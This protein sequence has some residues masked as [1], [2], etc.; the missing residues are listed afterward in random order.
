MAK[1]RKEKMVEHLRA[2]VGNVASAMLVVRLEGHISAAP[3]EDHALRLAID[4]IRVALR[5]FVDPQLA[6]EVAAGLAQ[7]GRL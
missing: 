7:I 2:R 6:E 4:K 3:D 5:L 1:G